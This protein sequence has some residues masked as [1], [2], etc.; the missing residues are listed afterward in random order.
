MKLILQITL[1]V[2]FGILL[3]FGIL[4]GGT[5]LIFIAGSPSTQLISD[6]LK[7]PA[8]HPLLKLP[9]L[10]ATP[11]LP[12]PAILPPTIQ[13]VPSPPVDT[14]TTEEIQIQQQ[15][16]LAAQEEKRK[17]DE[18]FKNWYHK[19][20]QCVSPNDHGHAVFVTCGNEYA[21]ARAK[22]EELYKQGKL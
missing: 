18:A 5:M 6:A 11:D 4:L 8:G 14:R 9:E 17:K 21:R 10:P 1:G 2:C 7:Q 16:Q 13:P 19:P 12:A 20:A 15:L 3:S 22:F